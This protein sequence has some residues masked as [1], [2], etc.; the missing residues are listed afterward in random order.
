MKKLLVAVLV[1]SF[2]LVAFAKRA[3]PKHIIS[4]GTGG[5]GWSGVAQVFEWDKD[6]SGTKNHEA[7][8]SELYLNY[9]YVFESRVML[10]ALI[11]SKT[12]KSEINYTD[13]D[14][15]TSESSDAELGVSLGY[16]FNEDL[17]NSWW[18]QGIVSSGKHREKTKN[19]AGN[20]KYN[21]G[22]SALYI[23]GGKRIN[24]DF[25]GLKNISYN[26]SLT[27]ASATTSGDAEDAGFEKM[28]HVKFEIIK[29][30]ILF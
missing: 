3:Q 13:G 8:K 29:F 19:S 11:L 18:I 24:L 5:F 16:N 14:K 23:K 27:I 28:T 25:W 26:P 4:I 10:G 6:K 15:T 20:K 17:F 22:F 9:S 1:S 30:D 7:S 2:S 12:S 21:Y